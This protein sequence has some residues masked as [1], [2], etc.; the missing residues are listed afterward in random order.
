MG[1]TVIVTGG[2]AGIGEACALRFGSEGA[3]VAVAD[4]DADRAAAVADAV[5]QAGGVGAAFACDVGDSASV[6]RLVETVVEK[7][8]DIDILVANAG[9][10]AGA[11]FLDLEEAE[12]DRVIR[13][14][15]KGVFLCGQ[16]VARHM[17]ARDKAAGTKK[18]GAIVNMSSTNAV[19]AIPNQVPYTTS[20]GGVNQLT[21]VMALSLV[22]HGIRVNAVGP[23]SIM[24]DI[25]KGVANNPEA[26]RKIYMRTPM[27]R[28]GEP[29]EIASVV[30]FLASQDAS[31]MTGQI[32]YA[33]GGRLP[34]N[35]I[36][37]V[38]GGE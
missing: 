30:A 35:Y 31:Y 1:K 18:G 26:T 12:F 33:D 20:K 3:N 16:A 36:V 23:G 6:Q 4:I 28:I 7:F 38:P 25:L 21:K 9:T 15:L 5:T 37:P 14:N 10:I 22:D 2:A 17:V 34:L 24:T 19:L 29:S 27:G 11:D 32:V 8:G 13:V